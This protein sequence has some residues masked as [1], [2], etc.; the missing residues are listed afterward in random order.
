MKK[1]LLISL[2]FASMSYAKE[3]VSPGFDGTLPDGADPGKKDEWTS[4]KPGDKD[5]SQEEFLKNWN[6]NNQMR[7]DVMQILLLSSGKLTVGKGQSLV[8][9]LSMRMAHPKDDRWRETQF[10]NDCKIPV[11]KSLLKCTLSVVSSQIGMMPGPGGPKRGRS[12]Y[13][14]SFLTY[15][16]APD[17][18]GGFAIQESDIPIFSY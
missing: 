17:G 11:G 8:E 3:Q 9:Y 10:A 2:L 13:E 1:L 5:N 7:P 12:I 14:Q 6:K 18:K 15:H 16:L 4:I